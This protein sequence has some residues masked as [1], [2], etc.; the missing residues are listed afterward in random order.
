MDIGLLQLDLINKSKKYQNLSKKLK[1]DITRDANNYITSFGTVPGYVILKSFKEKK[2]LLVEKIIAFLKNLFSISR[3]SGYRLYNFQNI[4]KFKTL[5]ISWTTVNDFKNDGTYRDSYFRTNSKNYKDILWILISSDGILPKKIDKNITILFQKNAG[6]INIL[7]LLKI[8]FLKI[9]ACKFSI[10]T[11]ISSLSFYSHLS[12]IILKKIHSV[13]KNENLDLVIMPYEAQPFQ[14]YLFKSV[15]RIK[16]KVKTVGYVHSTQPYP[17]HLLYRDGAPD[18][19]LVHGAD[20]KYHC[21]KY[22]NWPKNSLKLIPSLRYKKKD[23]FN[24]KNKIFLPYYISNEDFYVMEFEKIISSFRNKT[25]K[26][27]EIVNH[28]HMK[29]TKSHLKLIKRL[30]L[31]ISKNKKIFSPKANKSITFVFGGTSIVLEALERKYSFIHICGEPIFERYSSALWPNIE[32]KKIN[33]NTYKYSLKKLER[34][35]KFSNNKDL[36]EKN[37]LN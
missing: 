2:L 4:G 12:E 9:I 20:Q 25:I 23:K 29:K 34:C 28:P 5:I 36:F 7:Y 32:V 14:N 33:N 21:I 30:S 1:V 6:Q 8:F 10:R 31:V 3:T 16:K 18:K 27:L 26:P 19:L 24:F 17:I 22:L 13:F 35:I 15:K 37:C 11:L